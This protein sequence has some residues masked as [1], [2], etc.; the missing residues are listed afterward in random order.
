MTHASKKRW[1]SK[2]VEHEAVI[3]DMADQPESSYRHIAAITGFSTKTIIAYMRRLNIPLKFP[4]GLSSRAVRAAK[5]ST[6]VDP[7]TLRQ[8][9][10]VPGMTITTMSRTLGVHHN[11]V[12]SQL[13]CHGLHI[14]TPEEVAVSALIDI[15]K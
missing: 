5:P 3:R 4:K 11:S 7:S 12:A 13:R 2:S 1:N 15:G 10:D 6:I 8:L 9:C 14:V